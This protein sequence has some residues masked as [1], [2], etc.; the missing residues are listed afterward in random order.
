MNICIVLKGRIEHCPPLLRL[1]SFFYSRGWNVDVFCTGG[2]G[3][4]PAVLHGISFD[5]RVTATRVR[6]AEGLLRKM[7]P[8]VEVP[9]LVSALRSRASAD[10]DIVVAYNPYALL[11]CFLAGVGGEVPLVYYSAELY[12]EWR[13]WP[14]RLCEAIARGSIE[15]LI[16]CQKDRGRILREKLRLDVP[17]LVVPNS[18]F[19]YY[20]AAGWQ[21]KDP[22]W[23]TTS[24][25]TVFI[26]QGANHVGH[27]CLHELVQAFGDTGMNVVLRLALTGDP[28]VTTRLRS[29][30]ARAKHPERFEFVEYVPYPKHFEAARKCDAGVMLYHPDISLN[31]RYCAPNKLYEYAML[32]LPVLSS[33]QDHLR[34][35]IEGNGFGLCVNPTDCDA[36][37]EAMVQMTDAARLQEMSRRARQW[38]ETSGRYEVIASQLEEWCNTVVSGSRRHES[39]VCTQQ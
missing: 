33:N 18:C 22:N 29:L 32:G 6:E 36:I 28:R 13:F 14:Q 23:F 11:A 16:I 19:D 7:R 30:A 12:D 21:E 39:R 3:L 37:V 1:L 10:W 38:Y 9:R 2:C 34:T 26:Y 17:S 24:P 31:Y 8:A 20:Q 15:G 27:R 35:E 25:R 4:P 5:D